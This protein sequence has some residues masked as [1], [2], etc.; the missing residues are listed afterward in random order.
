MYPT[1]HISFSF[2]FLFKTTWFCRNTFLISFFCF[3]YK[4]KD[5]ALPDGE[6]LRPVPCSALA[7]NAHPLSPSQTAA[8]TNFLSSSYTTRLCPHLS[9]PFHV[10]PSLDTVFT[11]S[12]S[13]YGI[14]LHSIHALQTSSDH[15]SLYKKPKFATQIYNNLK[16]NRELAYIP[17]NLTTSSELPLSHCSYYFHGKF[18]HACQAPLDQNEVINI[19]SDQMC[20]LTVHLALIQIPH[21]CF[22]HLAQNWICPLDWWLSRLCIHLFTYAQ[23]PF[24][25]PKQIF[26]RMISC[27]IGQFYRGEDEGKWKRRVVEEPNNEGAWVWT[28]HKDSSDDRCLL[29]WTIYTKMPS[30][31]G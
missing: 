27:S 5:Y 10:M 14:R 4:R 11:A 9:N 24:G 17:A 22:Q 26:H 20:F 18:H 23:I 6:H 31:H 21:R 2:W 3:I 8:R 16:T 7:E 25:T 1:K 28:F 19:R 12:L 30:I 29:A 15:T 13:S